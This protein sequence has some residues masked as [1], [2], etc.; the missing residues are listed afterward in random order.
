MDFFG[1]P[2]EGFFVEVGAFDGES[3]SN[4]SGLADSGWKGIYVEP[5]ESHYNQCMK[6]HEKNDVSVVQ[7]SVGTYEGEIEI[8]EGSF[9]TTSD[10]EQVKRYSQIDWS[11][12]IPFQKSKCEQLR[13]DTLLNHFEVSPRFDLLVVDVEGRETDVFNS[14]DLNYWKPKM[15]IVEI[16]DEHESFK[17]YEDYIEM[18]KSLREKIKSSGYIELYKDQI[19]TVFINE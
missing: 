16:E 17:E 11:K 9:L 5:I 19:N 1:F 4:T 6:R 10:V 15:L 14:F 8:Y 7:C 12:N 13:L 3:F 2:Y 18:N